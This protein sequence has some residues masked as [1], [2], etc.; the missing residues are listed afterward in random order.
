[1]DVSIMA[2]TGGRER[3]EAEFRRLL[4][5]AGL[6]VHDMSALPPPA[7]LFMIEAGLA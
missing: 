7:T 3:T 6:V 1:M 4:E 5:T 2:L